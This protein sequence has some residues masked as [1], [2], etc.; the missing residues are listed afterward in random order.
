MRR[1]ILRW[2]SWL[3]ASETFMGCLI[4]RPPAIS[5]NKKKTGGISFNATIALTRMDEK[6]CHR[7]LQV[8]MP[9]LA[10]EC[11]TCHSI[12]RATGNPT[13]PFWPCGPPAGPTCTAARKPEPHLH[14]ALL[15]STI[16]P[17]HMP[18][19]RTFCLLYMCKAPWRAF[20]VP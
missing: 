13:N 19:S 10:I 18:L 9:T 1:I 6:L 17:T 2:S 11:C 4:R 15:D 8:L 7:I 12:H 14:I 5:F 16:C 3:F 20:S